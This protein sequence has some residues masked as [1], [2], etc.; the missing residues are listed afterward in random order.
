MMKA[1]RIKQVRFLH[2]DIRNLNRLNQPNESSSSTPTSHTLG[3]SGAKVQCC[4]RLLLDM[5][6]FMFS[7]SVCM[8]VSLTLHPWTT[9]FILGTRCKSDMRLFRLYLYVILSINNI[10]KAKDEEA[11]L[12]WHKVPIPGVSLH[13][14][15]VVST[16]QIDTVS[17]H[18]DFKDASGRK[19][20]LSLHFNTT[21]NCHTINE[22]QCFSTRI[23]EKTLNYWMQDWQLRNRRTLLKIL[24]FSAVIHSTETSNFLF[25]L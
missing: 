1:L 10:G 7:E 13:Y 9:N 25:E 23:A 19:T 20:V 4:V 3:K 2:V 17:S 6:A 18:W 8:L 22:I 11:S 24:W 5:L 15:S 16:G 14:T 12:A 21:I